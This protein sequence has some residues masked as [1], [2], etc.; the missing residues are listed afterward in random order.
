MKKKILIVEDNKDIGE[1]ISFILSDEGYEPVLCNTQ[2][3]IL[4]MVYKNRPDAILLDIIQPTELGTKL[5]R[6]LK[7]HELSR[8]IPI[9]VLS[10]HP[11]IKVV[12]EVCADDVLQ[13]P[14]DISVLLQ[15]VKEQLAA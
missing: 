2:A 10:T 4:N 8:D 1:I 13:K 11:Q 7:A 9:I 3:E 5:C 14:F 12:K 15:A 6:D